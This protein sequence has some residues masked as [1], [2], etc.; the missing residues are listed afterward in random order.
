VIDSPVGCRLLD[1]EVYGFTQ[2]ERGH[3]SST[4][5]LFRLHSQFSIHNQSKTMLCNLN[6]SEYVLQKLRNTVD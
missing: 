4:S 2:D 6:S 1:R 3:Q 5:Q